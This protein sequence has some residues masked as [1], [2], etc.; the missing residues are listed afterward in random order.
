MLDEAFSEHKQAS[1]SDLGFIHPNAAQ[2]FIPV[3][4]D[5]STTW[6]IRTGFPMVPVIAE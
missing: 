5:P 3:P 4:S 6:A 1:G 2:V